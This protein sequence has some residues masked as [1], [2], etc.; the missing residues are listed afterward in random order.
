[1]GEV[2]SSSDISMGTERRLTWVS[3]E[4][5]LRPSEAP[6][7]MCHGSHLQPSMDE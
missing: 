2:A 6:G 4:R 3:E 7:V 5:Q 1:M